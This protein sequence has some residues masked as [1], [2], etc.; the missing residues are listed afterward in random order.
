MMTKLQSTD[1]ERLGKEEGVSG[2][3]WISLGG[4]DRRDFMGR[5]GSDRDGSRVAQVRGYEV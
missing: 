1:P 2:D 5:L 3:T 4:G